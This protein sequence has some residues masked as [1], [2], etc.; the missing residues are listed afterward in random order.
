MYIYII[1][2]IYPF[3]FLYSF[4]LTKTVYQDLKMQ[5]TD[6][7]IPTSRLPSQV[8]RRNDSRLKAEENI[9]RE[10][11]RAN[12]PCVPCQTTGEMCYVGH[13]KRCGACARTD[14]S[15]A[16]CGV[17]TE[18]YRLEGGQASSNV[19]GLGDITMSDS[20]FIN[21]DSK[22]PVAGAASG[23]PPTPKG[24]LPSRILEE[25]IDGLRQETRKWFERVSRDVD[26]AGEGIYVLQD[27]IV[28]LQTRVESLEEMVASLVGTH[29]R[30]RARQPS[31]GRSA[32]DEM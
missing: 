32:P 27:I 14:I 23:A 31:H 7:S 9:R 13:A 19:A 4:L 12:I 22:I 2:I 10:G 16:K 1:I 30:S 29:P 18:N 3:L 6:R 15:V 8:P 20:P 17:D 24:Q 5:S 25:K 26:E 21:F 11:R 28:D